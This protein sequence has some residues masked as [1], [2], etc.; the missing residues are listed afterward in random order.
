MAKPKNGTEGVPAVKK[1]AKKP[2]TPRAKKAV[3]AKSTAGETLNPTQI[4]QE[5]RRRAYEL[6]L[7]RNGSYGDQLGD[8]FTAE[9][10]VKAKLTV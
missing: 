9:A 7:L 1:T 5:I 10:E 4:E 3:I 2:A 8:W 6:F